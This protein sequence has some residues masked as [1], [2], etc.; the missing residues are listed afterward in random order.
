MSEHNGWNKMRPLK[1][2]V[3]ISEASLDVLPY[4]TSLLHE[5]T[6][7][8]VNLSWAAAEVDFFCL[9]SGSGCV[10]FLLNKSHLA[11]RWVTPSN[12]VEKLS[13]LSCWGVPA[14]FPLVCLLPAGCVQMNPDEE[15]G[16]PDLF[17][18]PCSSYTLRLDS[19]CTYNVNIRAQHLTKGRHSAALVA[20]STKLFPLPGQSSI[21]NFLLFGAF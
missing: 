5:N 20:V 17:K 10:A 15:Q 19:P 6:I 2:A 12:T 7:K 3:A 4:K 18:W 11:E 14:R 21:L 16:N 9:V 8:A 1:S 13:V